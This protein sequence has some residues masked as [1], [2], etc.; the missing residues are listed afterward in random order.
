VNPIVSVRQLSQSGLPARASRFACSAVWRPPEPAAVHWFLNGKLLQPVDQSLTAIVGR[1]WPS[2]TSATRPWG[3]TTAM[4]RCSPGQTLQQGPRPV[5][6]ED[7]V[8]FFRAASFIYAK[9]SSADEAAASDL[10]ELKAEFPGLVRRDLGTDFTDIGLEPSKEPIAATDPNV[11]RVGNNLLLRAGSWRRFATRMNLLGGRVTFGY[12][13]MCTGSTWQQ[14]DGLL[15]VPNHPRPGAPA[16]RAGQFRAP[17]VPSSNRPSRQRFLFSA[18]LFYLN[19]SGDTVVKDF[20]RLRLAPLPPT[21]VWRD[22]G[23]V[24]VAA[25]GMQLLSNSRLSAFRPAATFCVFYAAFCLSKVNQKHLS[26]LKSSVLFIDCLQPGDSRSAAAA[27]SSGSLPPGPGG[28]NPKAS[29]GHLRDPLGP[30]SKRSRILQLP[31]PRQAS[32]DAENAASSSTTCPWNASGQVRLPGRHPLCPEL[33]TISGAARTKSSP[34]EHLRHRAPCGFIPALRLCSQSG[35]HAVS[36]ELKTQHRVDCPGPVLE[37]P[38]QSPARDSHQALLHRCVG[39]RPVFDL[40]ARTAPVTPGALGVL[41]CRASEPPPDLILL[42]AAPARQ[43]EAVPSTTAQLKA[44]CERQPAGSCCSRTAACD[45]PDVADGRRKTPL[46][47]LDHAI[48]E[49]PGGRQIRIEQCSPV[50][51]L[52]SS[53][54]QRKPPAPPSSLTAPIAI[55]SVLPSLGGTCFL[56]IFLSYVLHL[57]QA[58][59]TPHF[60]P[61]DK[62]R[63]PRRMGQAFCPRGLRRQY[64]GLLL[65][66]LRRTKHL[67]PASPSALYRQPAAAAAHSPSH[68]SSR[69]GAASTQKIGAPSFRCNSGQRQLLYEPSRAGQRTEQSA[70]LLTSSHH[71]RCRPADS[72]LL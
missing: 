12:F 3:C 59:E 61:A 42:D 51:Q 57:C 36:L 45:Q 68:S 65:A 64:S 60:D 52:A 48:S 33:A 1:E 6:P 44:G 71:R 5:L 10:V 50:L 41:H 16:F 30:D 29:R 38:Q 25:D 15:C 23:G 8:S 47:W 55:R 67:Y 54:C 43:G 40:T 22:P 17:A 21:A 53:L 62:P 4:R 27:T 24:A 14:A 26:Q 32:V 39:L 20:R 58:P 34:E 11:Q 28:G 37:S 9:V 13:F 72:L 18:S 49:S 19:V 46:A 69:G 7:M 35:Q 70:A 31:D 56:I 63:G 66:D 2:E